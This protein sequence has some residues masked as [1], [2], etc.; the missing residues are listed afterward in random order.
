MS[1]LDELRKKEKLSDIEECIIWAVKTD[2]DKEDA[3]SELAALRARVE[4]LEAERNAIAK[5]IHVTLDDGTAPDNLADH[6][7]LLMFRW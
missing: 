1:A 2:R 7:Q 6:V 5:H 4:K 3:I